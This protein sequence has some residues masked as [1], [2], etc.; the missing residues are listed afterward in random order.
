MAHRGLTAALLGV[1]LLVASRAVAGTPAQRSRTFLFSYDFTVKELPAGKAVRIWVPLAPSTEEQDM[2]IVAQKLPEGIKSS[3]G[4]DRQYGNGI[5]YAEGQPNAKGEIPIRVDFRV[6]RREVR[7]TGPHGT[8]IKVAPEEDLQR[9]LAPDAKVPVGGKPLELLKD[10]KVPTDQ[11]AAARLLYDVVNKHMTYSKK[12]K[13]WGEG[14]AVW[15]C[16]SKYG[17]CTDFHSLFISLARAE[18]IPSKFVMGFAIPGKRGS[19][20]I[21]GY[22]CW[23]WFQPR[24]KGWIPV[25]ISEANQNPSV[26]EYYFGNLTENRVQFTTGRDIV[27]EPRQN[28]APLNFFIC[29]HVEVEGAVYPLEKIERNFNH[30]DVE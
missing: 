13:G 30:R 5:L 22:H 10:K 7:T 29:P 26:Q 15:A 20:P 6:T 28:A 9:F 24:G 23:A 8:L 12:G 3:T 21:P 2:Q 14:D 1:V 18:K 25:D 27:L 16:D 19:A 11:F 4:K 17:N